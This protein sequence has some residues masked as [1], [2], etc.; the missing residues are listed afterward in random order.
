MIGAA[1]P[2]MGALSSSPGHHG[3]FA[4]DFCW[5]RDDSAGLSCGEQSGER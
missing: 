3:G 5:G 4:A 2:G 1:W